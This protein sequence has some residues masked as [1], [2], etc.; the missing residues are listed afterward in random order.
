MNLVLVLMLT[1]PLAPALAAVVAPPAVTKALSAAVGVG[2]FAATIALVPAAVHPG[3]LGIGFLHVDALSA[4]FLLA[5]GFLYAS[6]AVYSL[7]YLRGEPSTKYERRFYAGL[8]LF[9]WSMLA[10]PAMNGLALLWIAVEIT[11]V[12]SAL[13]VAIDYTNEA[14][15]A[16]WK[17]VLIASAGLGIA[18]LAT[19]FMYYAGATVLG[20][21]YDLAFVPLLHAGTALPHTAVRIAFV[22][23]VLGFGTKVGLFPVHTWLPDAHSQAPTPISA[24][25]SGAL[26]ATSFYAVLRFY[27]I[28]AASL[29]PAFPRTV[30]LVFGIASLA[31]AALYL[32]DQ[33]DI[34]RMLA[35]SSVEHMGILAIA[36]SFG[37]PLA[38]FG[39]LLHVLA[40][41]AAKG[42]AFFGAGILVRRYNTKDM[43]R[44]RGAGG[45]LPWTTPLFLLAVL[46]L[47]AMPPFGL[48]RSEFAIVA[49]GLQGSRN[50]GTV[51][52][53][54]LV[55]LA[56]LGLATQVTRIV[57]SPDPSFR[58]SY[59][60]PSEGGA[61]ESP[62]GA[63]DGGGSGIPTAERGEVSAW[64]V[65]PM[66][67]GLAALLLLGI[68]PP[69]GLSHLLTEAASQLGARP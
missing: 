11:T 59:V 14:I 51:L 36:V 41:A 38:L 16:S 61:A 64:T 28:A 56:F 50:A 39:A 42:N 69:T 62:A 35:Y 8:N 48:F 54:A 67:A 24:L 6:A 23:A 3:G 40:H 7:G 34:K 25:L 19:I 66:L 57:Y 37:A 58:G 33:R 63:P 47:S 53:V 4:V 10:A 1:V 5:T 43:N 45:V 15:E 55:T 46:A 32:L 68:Y 31:L 60:D 20:S 18:L 26:L 12:V 44:I 13:L 21:S 29:G 17:Y 65:A 52:L 9:A 49:G 30:L 22:L 27:E 2:A